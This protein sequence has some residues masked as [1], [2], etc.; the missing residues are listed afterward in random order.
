MA[1]IYILTHYC[2]NYS[3]Y[4]FKRNICVYFHRFKVMNPF[5]ITNHCLAHRLQLAEEKAANQV[6]AIMKYIGILDTFTKALKFSPK[7][8]RVEAS[9][10]E[11]NE[12]AP[13][14]KQAFFTRYTTK[15]VNLINQ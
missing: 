4:F 14:I 15:D 2:L 13:K 8:T 10:D 7:L 11:Y 1:R 5:M 3:I 6:P 12:K 9:K